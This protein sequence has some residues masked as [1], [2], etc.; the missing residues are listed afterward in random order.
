VLA[1]HE[2]SSRIDYVLVGPPGQGGAGHVVRAWRGGAEPV[3]GV[4]PSDHAAVVAEL[5]L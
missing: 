5:A 4:W 2:P 3:A 1:T